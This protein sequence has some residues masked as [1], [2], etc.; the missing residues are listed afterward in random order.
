LS[1]GR[2]AYR[3]GIGDVYDLSFNESGVTIHRTDNSFAVPTIESRELVNRLY[4]AYAGNLF[5]RGMNKHVII[6][7]EFLVGSEVMVQEVR[8]SKVTKNVP[9][10]N[11]TGR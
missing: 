3:C 5:C 9:N 1:W 2:C 8:Y 10:F 11:A 7:S 4:W 6:C